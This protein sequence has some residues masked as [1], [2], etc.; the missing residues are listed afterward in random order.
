MNNQDKL[1]AVFKKNQH[2]LNERPS[3]K[4]WNKLERKLDQKSSRPKRAPFSIYSILAMAAAV[5]GLIFFVTTMVNVTKDRAYQKA[6]VIREATSTE[7]RFRTQQILAEQAF[8]E[9]YQT[10]L[11]RTVEEGAAD[12]L[13]MVNK[14][15]RVFLVP[16]RG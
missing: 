3:L 1:S 8:R 14:P 7:E 16:R 4:A 15:V 6:V 5:V 2:K 10:K 9:K 12:K 13:L 11:Y